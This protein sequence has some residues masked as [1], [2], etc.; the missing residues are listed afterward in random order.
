MV[1]LLQILLLIALALWI[2]RTVREMLAPPRRP[3][4]AP[5]AFEPMARCARCAVHV[6]AVRLDARGLCPDCARAA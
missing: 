6:P 1:R 5:P 4:P 3:D 2:A